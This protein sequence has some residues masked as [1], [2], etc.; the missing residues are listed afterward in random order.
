M[1]KCSDAPTID[2]SYFL[3]SHAAC[4]ILLTVFVCTTAISLPCNTDPGRSPLAASPMGAG[5][6]INPA[7]RALAVTHG[8]ATDY[9]TGYWCVLPILFSGELWASDTASIQLA[10][11]RQRCP[12]CTLLLPLSSHDQ[13]PQT[14]ILPLAARSPFTGLLAALAHLGSARCHDLIAVTQAGGWPGQFAGQAR[15]SQAVVE[16]SLRPRQPGL[17]QRPSKVRHFV[18]FGGRG[19]AHPSI[20]VGLIS[21]PYCG[22]R[23]YPS[24]R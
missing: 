10:S 3:S 21:F 4:R 15:V 22:A 12:L 8:S 17:L 5:V 11:T 6:T 2:L 1:P 20:N 13:S 23:A 18:G 19:A 9:E 24:S 14:H 7:P 16:L